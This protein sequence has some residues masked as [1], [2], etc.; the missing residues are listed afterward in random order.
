MGRTVL[1]RYRAI[2]SLKITSKPDFCNR[3]IAAIGRRADLFFVLEKDLRGA[4]PVARVVPVDKGLHLPLCS[5][6]LMDLVPKLS[7]THTV[8]NDH[9]RKVMRDGQIEIFFKS[10]EL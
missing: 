10:L 4:I 1:N 5:K 6:D 9:R 3:A 8:D 7:G 2:M